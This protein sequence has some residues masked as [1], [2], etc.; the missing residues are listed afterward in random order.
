MM[1]IFMGIAEAADA[2]RI[3]LIIHSAELPEHL[4]ERLIARTQL[5]NSPVDLI[6]DFTESVYA[7]HANFSEEARDI[8]AA[9]A[10]LIDRDGYFGRLDGRANA[11]HMALRRETG[12]AGS[13]PDASN[14]PE[15]KSEFA[16]GD[17]ATPTV[18][19]A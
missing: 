7:N 14:D 17:V 8:A 5:G 9:C 11:I 18:P 13:W 19:A 6:R 2:A 12:A 15:P 4:A 16:P 1:K 10:S 3:W